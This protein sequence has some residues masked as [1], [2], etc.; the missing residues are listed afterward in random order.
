[1]MQ[2]MGW[3]YVPREPTYSGSTPEPTLPLGLY[4]PQT[5]HYVAILGIG[6]GEALLAGDTPSF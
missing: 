5:P 6:T 1:M 3:R 4:P 2:A